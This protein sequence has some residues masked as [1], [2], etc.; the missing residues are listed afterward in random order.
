V[1]CPAGPA[2]QR[3]APCAGDRGRNR[4]RR[5]VLHVRAGRPP[6]HAAGHHLDRH[7]ARRQDRR[8]GRARL[9]ARQPRGLQHPRRQPQPRHRGRRF[10]P[11]R[12][13]LQGRAPALRRGRRRLRR[14]GQRRPGRGRGQG[15]RRHL[16]LGVLRDGLPHADSAR[17]RGARGRRD[18][19]PHARR[20]PADRRRRPAGAVLGRRR[21]G[22]HHQEFVEASSYAAG[23]V[24]MATDGWFFAAARTMD[25]PP[26]SICSTHSSA[27][28]PDATVSANG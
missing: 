1:R 6:R 18:V 23:D 12:P 4:R 10:L 16:R 22:G 21:R 24:T 13:A 9:D 19:E 11:Q 14:R 28:A 8:A 7:H 2:P 26:M 15:G 17:R 25:G 3:P 5:L 20:L 27:S